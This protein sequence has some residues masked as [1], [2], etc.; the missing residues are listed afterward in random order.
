MSE[1]T[2]APEGYP[3]KLVRDKTTDIIGEHG[4]LFYDHVS[5]AEHAPWLRRKLLEEV[6]EYLAD[7]GTDELADVV[8]VVEALARVGHSMSMAEL[9]AL[10]LNDPRGG[11]LT[12]RMMRGFHLEFDMGQR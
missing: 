1:L 11:F 10:A 4:D 12:G 2:P 7:P 5:A 8:A 3:I 9:R 6:G